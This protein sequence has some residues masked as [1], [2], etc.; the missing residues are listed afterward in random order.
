[1]NG[2]ILPIN[3]NA[4]NQRVNKGALLLRR[5]VFDDRRR[6]GQHFLSDNQPVHRFRNSQAGEFPVQSIKL[7]LQGSQPPGDRCNRQPA[8]LAQIKQPFHLR[9]NLGH[10][11]L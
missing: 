4:T 9:A 7:L 11:G 5:S 10:A 2:Y 3:I 1:M 6:T 8:G